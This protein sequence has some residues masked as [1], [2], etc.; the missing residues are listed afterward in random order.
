[1]SFRDAIFQQI[2]L[3]DA[4]V[5]CFFYAKCFGEWFMAQS[6]KDASKKALFAE[7]SPTNRWLQEIVG[8]QIDAIAGDGESDKAPMESLHQYCRESE[9]LV[10]VFWLGSLCHQAISRAAA[11]KED[12]TYGK[13]SKDSIGKSRI[14]NKKR[15]EICTKQMTC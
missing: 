1:M 10:K 8:N 5:W 12:K 3:N 7:D 6:V 2:G 4:R 9:N 13:V 14:S 15:K 11:S